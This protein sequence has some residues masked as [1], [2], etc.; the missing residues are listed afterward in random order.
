MPSSSGLASSHARMRSKPAK[1]CSRRADALEAF[2]EL[3]LRQRPPLAQ[4]E[5]EI[6]D[7]G[8]GGAKGAPGGTMVTRYPS[9]ASARG[10]ASVTR[11][12]GC[13][14][15]ARHLAAHAPHLVHRRGPSTKARSAPASRYALARV[16]PR[17]VC[18]P[19]PRAS[20]RAM[21]TK[22]D[23]S[24]G[25]PGPPRDTCPPLRRA[26]SRG[27]PPRAASRADLVFDVDGGPAR[28]DVLTH[29]AHHVIALP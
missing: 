7:G 19:R 25:A 24:R 29:R 17:R 4:R 2:D 11:P 14:K 23:R 5:R 15:R 21:M 20:V 1:V 13:R 12:S 28:L 27:A 16:W 6:V 8:D 9:R 22:S 3:R 18:R 10:S 26:G